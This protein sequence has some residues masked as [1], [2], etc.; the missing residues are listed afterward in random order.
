[1]DL[2]VRY[3]KP[4]NIKE[5]FCEAEFNDNLIGMSQREEY[6]NYFNSL[7]G[8]FMVEKMYQGYRLIT[9]HMDYFI[10]R[11][12][13][14][15]LLP[16]RIYNYNNDQARLIHLF[17]HCLK[18]SK[19]TTWGLKHR[20]LLKLIETGFDTQ[21]VSN[22]IRKPHSQVNKYLIP[23]DVPPEFRSLVPEGAGTTVNDMARFLRRDN[24]LDEIVKYHLYQMATL[25]RNNPD[26]LI[27][28]KWDI[29]KSSIENAH[30][31][32]SLT[33]EQQLNW[34]NI[35][36]HYE[37]IIFQESQNNIDQQLVTTIIY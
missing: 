23:D 34:I 12:H 15:V 5:I 1:M 32:N 22:R 11:K 3:L 33:L 16:C 26:R 35:I 19:T 31:L 17:S 10:L 24:N 2:M 9:G 14:N 13:K 25:P 4:N 6:F 29:L 18:E 21:E 27:K 20:I 30:H 8:T 37:D 36:F 28:R 7:D